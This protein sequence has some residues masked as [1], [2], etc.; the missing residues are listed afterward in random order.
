MSN[1]IRTLY[2]GRVN[3]ADTDNP[4]GSIKNESVP[5][6]NDGTPLTAEWGN[7]VEAFKQAVLTKAGESPNGVTDTAK[8]SQ[9]FNALQKLFARKFDT[10]SAMQA[11][12][13][14][15]V[16]QRIRTS[17][18]N[19]DLEQDWEV[20]GSA[21]AGAFSVAL[22][23]G[24][25]AKEI[26]PVKYFESF[27][28]YADGATLD[29][30]AFEFAR[31]YA[32]D[33]FGRGD[34]IISQV[35]PLTN[36]TKWFGNWS[37]ISAQGTNQL[38]TFSS[39]VYFGEF[40]LDG[41]DGAHTQYPTQIV[42]PSSNVVLGDIVYRNF[43]GVLA[44]FQTYPLNIPMYG[45]SNFRVGNLE[46]Y[47]IT[48]DDD[49]SVTGPGFVGGVYIVG[50]DVEVANGKSYGKV[51][52]VFGHTIKSVDAGSGVVQDSDLIRVFA[53]TASTE[54]FDITFGNVTGRNVYKRLIKASSCGGIEF[55]NVKSY[56][57]QDPSDTYSLFAAVEVLS[58]G[59][60]FKFG[61]ITTEGPTAR[62]VWFKGSGNKAGDIY[63]GEGSQAVIF[64]EADNRATSCQVGNVLGRGRI[65]SA[66]QGVGVTFFNAN[67]C[68]TGNITGL[69]AVALNTNV[70]NTGANAVGNISC[71]GR[72]NAVNGRVTIGDIV[73]D[74]TITNVAG[75]HYIFG[76]TVRLGTSRITTDGRLT[77][78]IVGSN[79]D[80]DLGRTR[81]VRATAANG[82]GSSHSVFTTAS[83]TG[84]K[85]RGSLDIEVNATV[86]GTPSGSAGRTLVYITSVSID[87]FNL[88]MNVTASVRG[89][90]G[91]H[92]WLN[93]VNGQADRIA[94]KSRISIV[95]S[96]ASGK[97]G[98]TKA[99]YL[100][101]GGPT[102]TLSGEVNLFLAEKDST[103]TITGAANTP[104]VVNST[105]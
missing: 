48:Q 65:N 59:F 12:T 95:G 64:G 24:L 34:Y 57:P 20:T 68:Q 52:D 71:P 105:R 79:P 88:S 11:A 19:A 102:L 83:A 2:P 66:Q 39:N 28:A 101:P 5:G 25:F 47:N 49:G 30:S 80:V 96:Q 43:H 41:L 91:F 84:G 82:V 4:F 10:V 60:N 37:K 13:G 44:T 23:D 56:N 31:S 42:S 93:N 32:G 54:D 51:G 6:A 74:I 98:I 55:G 86:S 63:D 90:T 61:D 85:L 67:Q 99:E 89:A 45:A 78:S 21:P 26:S 27:G 100:V 97:L 76:E 18:F 70:A 92:Y 17:R 81:I 36:G 3:P 58:T 1:D 9:I 62:C 104:V 16:G 22:A 38:F 8:N 33:V 103:A 87:D 35:H 15:I 50:L 72:V 69:F 94:V 14:L 73:A 77:M 40:E 29:D 75:S 53:Q 46:F 7:D